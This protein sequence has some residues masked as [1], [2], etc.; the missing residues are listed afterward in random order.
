MKRFNDD[1]TIMATSTT[2]ALWYHSVVVSL[3]RI[4]TSGR[5]IPELDGMRFIAVACVFVQ[6]SQ[7]IMLSH[8]ANAESMRWDWFSTIVRESPIGVELFF[9]ISGFILGLPFAAAHFAMART[10]SLPNV[11]PS[12]FDET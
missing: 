4:T 12:S 10:V 6:H 5:Y 7:G 9:M 8:C 2:F 11:L 1:G 3:S